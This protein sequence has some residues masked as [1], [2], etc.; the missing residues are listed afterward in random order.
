M[1]IYETDILDQATRL[2]K[3]PMREQLAEPLEN[4]IALCK[5]I[6]P[7]RSTENVPRNQLLARIVIYAFT[8]NAQRRETP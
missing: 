5:A 2:W 7:T 4:L 3:A 6:D 8:Q 1:I